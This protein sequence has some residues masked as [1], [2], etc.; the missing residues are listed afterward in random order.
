LSGVANNGAAGD[1]L[2]NGRVVLLAGP[3]ASTHIVYHALARAF[4]EVPVILEE[5]VPRG[6]LVKRRLK[7]LGL[8]TVAGQMLFM[9]LAEPL[10]RRRAA[11]RVAA[12]KREHGLDDAPISGRVISVPSVNSDEA[13]RALR[14]LAPRF[15]VV[16]GTRIISKETL[17]AVDATFVNT[18]AGI[19]PAFRGVHGGYWALAEGRPDLA[20][21]TVHL[22]DAGI[23]TGGILKQVT[24]K[25]TPEDSF[26][27]YPYLQLAAGVPLLV[28]A[29]GEL[30]NGGV[31]PQKIESDLPSRL[32]SHPTLWGYVARRIRR[33]VR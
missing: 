10:L 20:G 33:G 7:K 17:A 11:S 6:Q 3:G 18:H 2:G 23:D 16:N 14:E 24:F 32:R 30:M 9:A 13:R 8:P 19:T 4:G 1:A 21:T 12:I 25:A 28:A 29:L 31:R 27:T 22:V 5:R 15:V 26:V